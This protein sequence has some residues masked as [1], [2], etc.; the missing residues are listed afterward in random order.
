MTDQPVVALSLFRRVIGSKDVATGK[1]ALDDSTYMTTGSKVSTYREGNS[2][3][4]MK[5]VPKC[6]TYDTM[7]GKPDL[8]NC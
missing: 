6:A 1:V 2:T 5:V 4:Q 3:I 8:S 7:T